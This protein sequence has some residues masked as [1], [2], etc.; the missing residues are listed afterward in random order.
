MDKFQPKRLRALPFF[1]NKVFRVL[2]LILFPVC[3]YLAAEL[4]QAQ[5]MG[6]LLQ[7]TLHRAGVA[8]FSILLTT[9]IFWVGTLL[10]R[11]AWA[12]GLTTGALY[13]I[14]SAVEYYKRESSG[15][16]LLFS[17]IKMLGDLSGL[18]KF[19]KLH[20]SPTLACC[21]L[22]V[23]L[24]IFLLWCADIRFN[25]YFGIRWLIS[26]AIAW[27]T[28]LVVC[29]PTAFTTVCLAFG[30]DGRRSYNTFSDAE[31]FDNNNLISNLVVSINQAVD[32]G[33]DIP[34]GYSAAALEKLMGGKAA[35]GPVLPENAPNLIVIMSETFADFRP[36]D[37]DPRLDGIYSQLDR[38]RGQGQTGTAVVPTFGG[39]TVKTE[40]ELLFGL[41]VKSL[42]DAFI[43]HQLLPND[44]EK[45]NTFPAAYQAL[46]YSTSYIHPYSAGF[47][48][49]G[50][51]YSRYGFDRML[52]AD[53]L[54]VPVG[55][56][57]SGYVDDDTVYRQAEAIMAQTDGPDFIHITSM[58]NHM[59]Y[60]D[61]AGQLSEY[62]Y[63]LQGIEKSCGELAD[64]LER[65]GKADEPCIVLFIGDHFPYFS[66]EDSIYQ[67]LS[68]NSENCGVLYEQSFLLWSNKGLA[69]PLPEETISAFYLPHLLYQ[70]ADLPENP[71]TEAVLGEMEKAPVYSVSLPQSG[72]SQLLDMLAYDRVLGE[73][74][75]AAAG[76][77]VPRGR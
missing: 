73:G 54:T 59:P 1:Q 37:G 22:F 61:P 14:C 71:F 2:L 69:G 7:F 4:G 60:D 19:T 36:L 11:R 20:F 18:G 17:D 42:G 74:Y 62:E 70:A 8:L 23:A 63:Y 43:P 24:L 38:V 77:S 15:S 49:R 76:D 6:A 34:K 25:R 31:R 21:F 3:L 48:D 27:M 39:G 44:G 29:A 58:Q 72:S 41:P 28:A 45:E 46:G 26:G 9:G 52:F 56:F 40:F 55:T 5:D 33:V 12:G 13:M 47:Y 65:L 75:S 64:F 10:T 30:L 35:E 16:H 68:I 57:H 50:D 66:G 53:D 51:T 67:K 32:S